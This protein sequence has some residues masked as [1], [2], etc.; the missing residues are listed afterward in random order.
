MDLRSGAGDRLPVLQSATAIAVSFL[1]CKAGSFITR[2]YG[3]QGGM[4][5][6]VTAIVVLLATMFPGQ[7]N[8]LAPSGEVMA[9]IL[10]QV[11]CFY[12]ALIF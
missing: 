11:L 10:M 2:Y 12:F 9:M 8:Q 1:I 5:P 6:A 7:F 4:L 3:I